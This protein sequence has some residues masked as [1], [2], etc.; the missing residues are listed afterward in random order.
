ML[1]FNRDLDAELR[2]HNAVP[3]WNFQVRSKIC[4]QIFWV[5]K[6]GAKQVRNIKSINQVA[7]KTLEKNIVQNLNVFGP[8]VGANTQ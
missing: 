5:G 8:R 2:M 4:K 1:N 6:R 7:H 3:T